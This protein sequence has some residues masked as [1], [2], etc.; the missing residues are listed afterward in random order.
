MFQI[1]QLDIG[2]V[3]T[4]FIGIGGLVGLA[5]L[6]DARTKALTA[7][8]TAQDAYIKK[9]E[10]RLT[11]LEAARATDQEQYEAT[12]EDLQGQI[13]VLKERIRLL[14]EENASYRNGQQPRRVKQ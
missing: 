14:Q 3:I 8:V 7:I 12:I 11:K 9:L 4:F 13:T 6:I 5:A 10:E 1:D 2:L